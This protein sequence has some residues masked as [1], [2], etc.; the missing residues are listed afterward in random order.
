MIVPPSVSG[1][2]RYSLKGARGRVEVDLDVVENVTVPVD[3]MSERVSLSVGVW[4]PLLCAGTA[5]VGRD[6]TLRT[7]S[8][9]LS[10]MPLP[11]MSM[12]GGAGGARGR[13][14]EGDDGLRADQRARREVEDVVVELGLE[15][16]RDSSRRAGSEL[17]GHEREHGV[18]GRVHELEGAGGRVFGERSTDPPSSLLLEDIRGRR[19]IAVGGVGDVRGRGHPLVAHAGLEVDD[20]VADGGRGRAGVRDGHFSAADHEEALDRIDL[21][22]ED[23][24]R[25]GVAAHRAGLLQRPGGVARLDDCRA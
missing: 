14:T 21:G 20:D 5:R 9:S 13:V 17:L 19:G 7:R 1:V 25:H 24:P 8:S 2:D 23:V 12:F 11:L 18:V 4:L 10:I 3:V 6:G 15:E 16:E 22:R